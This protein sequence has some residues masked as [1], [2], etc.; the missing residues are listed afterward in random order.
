MIANYHYLDESLLPANQGLDVQFTL[1]ISDPAR[2]LQ[3]SQQ[4]DGMFASSGTPT[5]ST[6][7]RLTMESLQNSSGHKTLAIA[8][9]GAAGLFMI[10]VLIANGISQSVRQRIPELAVLKTVGFRNIHIMSLVFAEVAIPCLAGAIAG[11]LLAI[12]LVHWP[13]K[14]LPAEFA[15]LP[16]PTL[17][18]NTMLQAVA[19]ALFIACASA[20]APLVRVSRMSVVAQLARPGR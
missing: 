8:I 18:G 5:L 15:G 7:Q 1:K 4:I 17:S 12:Q 3:I 11:T 2:A 9:V 6:S 13:A 20:A 16:T 10:L 14:F 19:A